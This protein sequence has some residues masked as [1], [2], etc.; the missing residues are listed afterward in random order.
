MKKPI[1]FLTII[2]IC[3]FAF[4]QSNRQ[5][6]EGNIAFSNA[7]Y[8]KA[9]SH[10][11][12]GAKEYLEVNDSANYGQSLLLVAKAQTHQYN[13]KEALETYLS[14]EKIGKELGDLELIGAS[15]NAQSI[16]Q[17]FLGS[18]EESAKI[19]WRILAGATSDST[20][21]S[22][23]YTVLGDYYY[24][25]KD[26]DSTLYYFQKA[27]TLDSLSNNRRSIP[28]NYARL[29]ECYA[30]MGLNGL[31]LE[32]YL[33]GL[34]WLDKEKESF[35]L[36]SLYQDIGALFLTMY[37][38]PKAKEYGDKALAL[39]KEHKLKNAQAECL[40]LLGEIAMSLNDYETARAYFIEAQ[41]LSAQSKRKKQL[42]VTHNLLAGLWLKQGLLEKAVPEMIAADSIYKEMGSDVVVTVHELVHTRM[43]IERGQYLQADERISRLK[44]D[45]S[46]Q[47]SPYLTRQL[48][49]LSFDLERKRGNLGKAIVE[50]ERARIMDDSLYKAEQN[51]IVQD[52]EAKYDRANK[53]REIAQLDSANQAQA[54]KLERKS[55][56]LMLSIVGGILSLL[57]ILLVLRLYNASKRAHSKIQEK[58]EIISK[59]LEEKEL[60]LREIHHRVKNNLQIISSLLSIQSRG[61]ED[62]RALEA[63]N[64][65]RNRVK[66][67][68]LI[69]QDLYREDNLMG[70]EAHE[71]IAKLTRSL[72]NSY[73][74]DED[75]VQ[76]DTNIDELRLD[77]DTSIPLGL[78]LNELITN[79]LK[80]AFPHERKGHIMIR[81]QKIGESLEL[82]VADDG[83]GIENVTHDEDSASFGTKMI[84]AFANK[85]DAKWTVNSANGTSIT[86]QIK[87]FKL[88]S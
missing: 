74:I 87:K 37:N 46:L 66:S 61:I 28:F 80:Y 63:V 62:K 36:A 42:L 83:I 41:E 20:Y 12:T 31:A 6:E 13:L 44:S 85:L 65:S 81:L 67:M 40:I 52:I 72:F 24:R 39:A 33:S 18:P 56:Q 25:L 23:A 57:I 5:I 22:D 53:E 35:K 60:L 48:L 38:I 9:L 26:L 14:V 11:T 47:H 54:L 73:R 32:K 55:N 27:I 58:N 3:S 8:D 68:A 29:G 45:P 21:I 71:Y 76:L 69:H 19:S 59:N 86:L 70:I 50:L 1:S 7:E 78:I 51:Y 49:N 82:E 17:N 15:L 75:R 84:Q 77:V 2:L 43:N 79:A 4:G 34:E 30:H 16:C 10:F 64:V 88:A